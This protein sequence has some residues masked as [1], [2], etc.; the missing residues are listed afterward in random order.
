MLCL[1]S[2][3]KNSWYLIFTYIFHLSDTGHPN[4]PS[5]KKEP[6]KVA[7]LTGLYLEGMGWARQGG[8]PRER[9]WQK[10]EQLIAFHYCALREL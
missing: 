2:H 5:E 8:G 9:L 10:A 7:H 4:P 1:E 6:R 3:Q